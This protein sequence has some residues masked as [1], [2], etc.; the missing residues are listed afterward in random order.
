MDM[1]IPC[2]EVQALQHLLHTIGKMGRVSGKFDHV[3]V[4]LVYGFVCGLCVV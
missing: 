1:F 3:H 4:G 2:S